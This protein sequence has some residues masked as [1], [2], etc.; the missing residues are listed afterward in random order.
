MYVSCIRQP[1]IYLYTFVMYFNVKGRSPSHIAVFEV[2]LHLRSWTK[3]DDGS[4][5]E[6]KIVAS[7]IKKI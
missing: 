5:T 1:S 4:K 2:F 7:K 6:P 3:F